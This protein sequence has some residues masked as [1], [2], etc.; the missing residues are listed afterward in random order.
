M[1]TQDESAEL[2]NRAH[3]QRTTKADYGRFLMLGA[4]SCERLPSG[5][6]LKKIAYELARIG[7]NLNQ[8]M[9]AINTAQQSEQLTEKQF[10]ALHNAITSGVEAWA[11]PLAELRGQL[12]RLK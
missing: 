1:L 10:A 2:N 6:S 9:A 11:T 4:G 3:D 8:A 5:T 7:G 12:D